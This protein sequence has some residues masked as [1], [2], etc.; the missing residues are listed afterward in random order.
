[1]PLYDEFLQIICSYNYTE[2]F[3]EQ[4]LINTYLEF[5]W[6]YYVSLVLTLIAFISIWNWCSL[7]ASKLSAQVKKEIE[8]S[9]LPSY[10]IMTCAILDQDQFPNIS[11]LAFTILSFCFSFFFFIT[12][13]CFMLNMM[14]TDLVTI[15]EPRVI[16][17]YDDIIGREDL[18]VVFP[19]GLDEEAFFREAK[20][21]SKEF[22]IWQKR[23]FME[24]LSAEAI[25]DIWQP[26]IDQ[27][28]IFV[29]RDWVGLAV[30]NFG[31]TKSREMGMDYFRAIYTKDETGK[32]FTNAFLIQK[33]A[34][35]VFKD[36]IYE[37]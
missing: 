22:I 30:A 18:N 8:N 33:E 29:L 2:H 9:R 1:M 34:T 23:R 10:W 16:T 3:K 24:E 37:R 25:N 36:Y 26:T 14:R 7:I 35:Q 32:F 31:I 15:E 27:R 17:S 19:K 5:H 13:N 20:D 21:G 6:S 12:V 11:R 4:D 28:L